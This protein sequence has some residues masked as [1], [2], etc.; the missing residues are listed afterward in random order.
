MPTDK[1]LEVYY[2]NYYSGS[3]CEQSTRGEAAKITFDKP[4][5][6]VKR[7]RSGITKSFQGRRVD[8][9]DF[10][11]GDGTVSSLL[12]ATLLEENVCKDV[13][14]VLVD[15][16]GEVPRNQ[17]SRIVVENR[18]RLEDDGQHYDIVIASAILEHIPSPTEVLRS[19]LCSLEKGGVFY[20][21]TPSHAAL[22]R[23]LPLRQIRRLLFTYPGHVHDMGQHFWENILSELT[24]LPAFRMLWSRP[25]LVERTWRESFFRTLAAYLLKAPWHVLGGRY[26]LVGGWEVLIQKCEDQAV[27]R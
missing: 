1:A 10:G 19:L 27:E 21:R 23:L 26:G 22:L 17:E 12:G 11:G 13:R 6:L 9:L 8:I 16:S 18:T 7:I 20:A 3:T 25:S 4:V 24:L 14:I 5:R 2:G 15:L